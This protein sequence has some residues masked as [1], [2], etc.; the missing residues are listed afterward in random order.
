LTVGVPVV[1]E[2]DTDLMDGG[3]E[4]SGSMVR[5]GGGLGGRLVYVW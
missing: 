4:K 5:R 2:L 3:E 1:E